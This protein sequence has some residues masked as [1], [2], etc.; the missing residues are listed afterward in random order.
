MPSVSPS[1]PNADLPLWL[2]LLARLPFGSLYALAAALALLLRYVLH[3]RVSVARS[4]LQRSFPDL[5]PRRIESI[6]NDYYRRLGQIIAECL[7]LAT[8]SAEELRQRVIITNLHLLQREIDAGR[9][10]I[11]LAAHLGNWEWQLQGTAVQIQSP[12]DAA[13]KPLHGARSNRLLLQLRSRFG[14]RMVAAKKLMRVVAR[15]RGAVHV[16]A[17]MAD[18]IPASSSGR[19]WLNFLGRE[20]AFYPGPGEIARLTGYT[21]LFAG[22]RRCSRGHY[23]ITFQPLATA[24]EPCEPQA[25]TARYA[26]LLEAQIR[27]DPANW[28]WSHRRWKLAPPVATTAAGQ[29]ASG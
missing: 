19:H 2:R 6:L 29:A 20:T 9:S 23:E 12:I 16:V 15:S 24:G 14:A 7:K 22:M 13:Y 26:Q 1:S 4:N 10:V 21:A 18:Q 3:Y 28:M 11:L 27:Q 17:L 8:I 5:P 25:F